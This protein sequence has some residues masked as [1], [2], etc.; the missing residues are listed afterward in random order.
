M[1][2]E[3]EIN[4]SNQLYSDYLN[5]NITTDEYVRYLLYTQYDTSMLDEKYQNLLKSDD[6]INIE[7][8]IN[9]YYEDLKK[10]ILII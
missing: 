4:I 7:E 3:T 2:P 10:L 8:L 6:T 9:K 5:E 1:P